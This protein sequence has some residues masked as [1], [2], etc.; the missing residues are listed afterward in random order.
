MKSKSMQVDAGNRYLWTD[1]SGQHLSMHASLIPAD[2]TATMAISYSERGRRLANLCTASK[3]AVYSYPSPSAQE[4]LVVRVPAHTTSIIPIETPDFQLAVVRP[5]DTVYLG[6]STEDRR[7]ALAGAYT[8]VR[9]APYTGMMNLG[10]AIVELKDVPHTFYQLGHIA[11]FVKRRGWN[12]FKRSLHEAAAGYL[13]YRFGVEATSHD[14]HN[15][16]GQ[17][18]SRVRAGV[19][20]VR[21]ERGQPIRAGFRLDLS[22]EIPVPSPHVC[23]QQGTS[24]PRNPYFDQTYDLSVELNC[25]YPGFSTN[26]NDMNFD[27]CLA[28]EYRVTKYQG[29]CF[30]TVAEQYSRDIDPHD[31]ISFNAG[32]FSTAWEEI[33]FSFVIDWFYNIGSA[34][35]R[36]EK[37]RS[38]QAQGSVVLSDGVWSSIRTTVSHYWPLLYTSCV[39]VI[40]RCYL[41]DNKEWLYLDR[42]VTSHRS[43]RFIKIGES[44]AYSRDRVS[45][46]V[47]IPNVRLPNTGYQ[48]SAGL[49]LLLQQF[50]V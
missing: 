40:D 6:P 5:Y 3:D 12:T 24:S 42:H 35:S 17:I 31:E 11:Q 33:P 34:I 13:G 1:G 10:T 23:T 41:S 21:Y 32:I 18:P 29:C 19:R 45:P 49:A 44:I 48:L 47:T 7:N 36:W 37:I 22:S 16:I 9:T 38:S 30:G 14:V 20:R 8:S 50:M 2:S 15:F 25:H 26:V 39:P 46:S 4:H 27:S 28:N 43:G